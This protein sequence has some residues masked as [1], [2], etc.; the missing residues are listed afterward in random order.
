[1]LADSSGLPLF[2]LHYDEA[3]P[4]PSPMN[5]AARV[6]AALLRGFVPVFTMDTPRCGDNVGEGILGKLLP[7]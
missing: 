5:T 4:N 1:M 7:G 6:A 3:M 2:N